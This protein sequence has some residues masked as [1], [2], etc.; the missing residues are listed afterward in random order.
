[1]KTKTY[2]LD[3]EVLHEFEGADLGWW[4]KGHHDVNLFAKA[5]GALV[6]ANPE[7][8]SAFR[9]LRDLRYYGTHWLLT[10]GTQKAIIAGAR[11]EFWACRPYVEYDPLA[12]ILY[13]RKGPGR[14]AFPVTI[15]EW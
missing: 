3:V 14:G 15:Y 1:M 6:D 13:E 11:H 5:C 9:D 12:W 8:G 2:P 10:A 4:T 7:S